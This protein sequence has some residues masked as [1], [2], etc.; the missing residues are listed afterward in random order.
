MLDAE[1]IKT[2][3]RDVRGIE[4]LA[5]TEVGDR[6][7]IAFDGLTTSIPH[8]GSEDQ[9]IAAIRNAAS[10]QPINPVATP[11]APQLSPKPLPTKGPAMSKFGFAAQIRSM[12]DTARAELEQ[13]KADGVAQ[14]KAA[15]DEHVRAAAQV[16]QVSASMAGAIN[17]ETAAVLAE[18]GQISNMPP[19]E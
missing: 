6:L 8:N 12:F 1:A 3:L 4:T 10:L 11:E 7:V 15:V 19:A 14:V 16:K 18:L 13:A 17:D 9:A 5:L 2:K